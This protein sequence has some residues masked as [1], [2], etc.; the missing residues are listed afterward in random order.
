M[1]GE[2]GRER[3]RRGPA[4]FVLPIIDGSLVLLEFMLAMYS[5]VLSRRD[6]VLF[7]IVLYGLC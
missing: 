4:L 7:V 5:G 1:R 2:R 3:E 6:I